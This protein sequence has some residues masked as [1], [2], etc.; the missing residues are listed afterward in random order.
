MQASILR[1]FP[2]TD[3]RLS[4]IWIEMLPTDSLEAARRMADGMIDPRVRHY[5][6]PRQTHLA[7][8]AL[9]HGIIAEGGGPAWDVYLFYGRE[10]KW[11]AEPPLPAEWCHQLSGGQRAD[12][13]RYAGGVVAERLHEEMHELTRSACTH[14]ASHE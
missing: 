14:A 8:K 11:G 6:D 3:I 7:G 10:A 4:V 13:S 5:F 12:P 2:E 9:A 1:S